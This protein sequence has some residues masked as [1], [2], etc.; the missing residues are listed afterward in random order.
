MAAMTLPS[1]CGLTAGD[2][3]I[4]DQLAAAKRASAVGFEPMFV[5]Q[6]EAEAAGLEAIAS[7]L[8]DPEARGV[9]VLRHGNGGET[10]PPEDCDMPWRKRE[11]AQ[12]VAAPSATLAADASLDRLTL[13]RN[14]DAL[15]LAVEAAAD[16]GAQ[17]A[18]EKMLAHECGTAHRV[19]MGLFATVDAELHKHR[20]APHLNPGALTEATR[21]ANAAA[22]VMGAFVQGVLALD[23]LRNGSRQTVT[24]QHVTVTDGGQAVVAGNVNTPKPSR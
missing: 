16:A 5:A 10:A 18:T 7:R 17:T 2:A 6:R 14:A 20:V 4:F 12:V 3:E 8:R 13:A 24:V 23:R 11:L 9:P 22:R 15:N 21:C 1:L 19:S